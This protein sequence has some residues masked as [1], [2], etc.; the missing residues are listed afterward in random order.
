MAQCDR[1][2]F[3]YN[4]GSLV[5]S[6]C[7]T[8]L[9]YWGWLELISVF[10]I[11]KYRQNIKGS[12][13][14]KYKKE[15]ESKTLSQIER[16]SAG[17]KNDQIRAIEKEKKK[18]QLDEVNSVKLAF[19]MLKLSILP[20]ENSQTKAI[21]DKDKGPVLAECFTKRLFILYT[22]YSIYILFY[23]YVLILICRY[24]T[25]TYF[26][27]GTFCMTYTFFK[28]VCNPC[29][30]KPLRLFVTIYFRTLWYIELETCKISVCYLT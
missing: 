29:V 18:L 8:F 24:R 30:F 9:A 3:G 15:T 26:L 1:G 20:K 10:S 21:T 14:G 16:Y 25:M 17:I 12:R 22:L 13:K 4:F 27:T 7:D 28:S 5:R 6:L 2:W 23:I 11:T 19:K